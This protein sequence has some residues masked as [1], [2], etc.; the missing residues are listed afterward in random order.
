[1]GNSSDDTYTLEDAEDEINI[2][3]RVEDDVVEAIENAATEE[4]LQYLIAEQELDIAHDGKRGLGKVRKAVLES[5]LASDRLKRLVSLRG[6]ETPEDILVPEDVVRNAKVA[7]EAGKPVVLY[8]PTGTG[9]TT[10]AK[11]LARETGIGYSLHTATPSW[12]PSDIIGGISPDYT[13][14]SLSYR[15]KLGCVSE[16]V[17]RARR[18]D[19]EYGVIL[20]EI[21]RADISKIFGPLY[22][23]IENPHQTIFET[24]EGETIEL[25]ERVNIICTMNMSDRT[26]NELDNAITRRFAMIE[27]D[28][29]EEDKRRQLFKDW[30]NTHISEATD[31]AD[32][33][34]LRLFERDYEGINHGH[35]ATAQGTIM[36]FG[37]MHYRD[38]AVFLGV[39]CREGGEYEYDQTDAVGQAFRTYIVPRL[40]NSAAFPQVERIAEH[41]RTLNDEFEEFDL[42]PAAKLAERELEQERRQMGSYE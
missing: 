33:E 20:D 36:R 10:F 42:T 12:T 24:D 39:G 19:V 35:E 22:T 15:T 40:L 38:V 37:P 8:G 29:Y 34:I 9:K 23:A 1:M 41:Y 26:V 4:V 16:G 3:R 11:Q 32:A 31:L 6:D 2:L 18:F 21:T 25:D 14:E 13:G 28:E 5:R 7:L 17:R 27:L 30:I